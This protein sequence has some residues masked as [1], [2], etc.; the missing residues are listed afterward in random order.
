MT[1][2]QLNDFIDERI[3]PNSENEIT[4]AKHNAV[5]KALADYAE[6]YAD[7][8][9]A[10]EAGNRDAAIS[11]AIAGE[12]SNRNSAIAS[13]IASEVS[14]R[15]SAISTAISQEVNDRNTAIGA[16]IGT[17][18]S[19][20]NAAIDAAVLAA[21]NARYTA[22]GAVYDSGTGTWSMHGGLVTG[23][24]AADMEVICAGAD[25]NCGSDFIGALARGKTNRPLNSYRV[26]RGDALPVNFYELAHGNTDL[27]V[28]YSPYQNSKFMLCVSKL[29]NAFIACSNL[30]IVKYLDVTKCNNFGTY[31]AQTQTIS[32]AFGGC[33]KLEELYM[34]GIGD[35]TTPI[36]PATDTNNYP[37]LDLR[38]CAVLTKASALYL[39]NNAVN[40]N[41]ICIRFSSSVSWAGDAEVI[42]ACAATETHARIVLEFM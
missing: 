32:S 1:R 34:K 23:I 12:V 20:R 24:T 29:Q 6:D 8:Q 22:F 3:Y 33:T 18:V 30:R 5:D 15:N 42:A 21:R 31:S 37:T 41:R 17:E 19:N 7:E 26:V 2:E 10:S 38:D 9:V 16:A 39:I 35:F 25:F 28:F 13:A 4:A 36:A 27:E 40:Q 11:A 14:A